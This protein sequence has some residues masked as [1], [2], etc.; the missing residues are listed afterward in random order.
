MNNFIDILNACPLFYNIQKD[1]I[2]T[3]NS[4]LSAVK[5]QFKKNS[6]IF[7]P[8][9]KAD[10]IGIVLSGA[11]DILR[12]DF[13]G[14]RV[15]LTRIESGGLFGEAFSCA[16]VE[17]LPVSV[18]AIEDSDIFLINCGSILITCA[19][20]CG[21]HTQIIKNLVRIL[22]NKNIMLTQ[23]LEHVT[24]RTTREK[25]LSYLS[26]QGR[27]NK[28]NIFDIP[29]NRQELADYLSVDRS[30]MSAEL[31]RMQNENLLRFKRNHFELL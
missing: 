21:F 1:D 26:E 14:N 20:A 16:Q 6:F 17:K 24:Q 12:E 25:L 7:A 10:S 18:M 28:S 22:A 4:C 30:S 8:E 5:K 29:F 2:Y 11:V 9:Q 13:W 15:I 31:S 23:K 27:I 19:D 3:L